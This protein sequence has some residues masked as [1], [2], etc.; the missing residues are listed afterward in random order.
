[1]KKKIPL[2]KISW[3]ND[4]ISLVR[5]TIARGMNWS[6]GPNVKRFENILARYVGTKY[7]I[8]F[9][10]GT[11]SLLAALYAHGIG[12]GDE[13]IVPS[14]S[15]ISVAMAP[16]F[17]NA[18]PVFVDIEDETLGIDP[19]RVEAKITNNTRAIIM[20][21]YGGCLSKIEEIK[22]IA[23]RHNLLLI[24]D[25]A[26]AFGLEIG[27]K[28]A[29]AFGDCGVFSFCQNKA[30]TTGD[31]GC[32]VTNS[33]DVLE[34]LSRINSYGQTN[35][36]CFYHDYVCLGLNLRMSDITAALGIAQMRKLKKNIRRRREVAKR[37]NEGLS[38]I[39][40][41]V[42]PDILSNKAA[43]ICLFYS[44]CVKA[45][46]RDR[47][48]THL[49]RNGITAKV[50]HY[51]AHLSTFFQQRSD[52]RDWDLPVT[53]RVWKEILSLP[54]YPDMGRNE[55]DYIVNCI[56]K[57]FTKTAKVHHENTLG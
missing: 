33:K 19:K 45:G 26:E 30:I 34:K 41:V 3:D 54:I 57:Y 25:A 11:S 43:S 31:G 38:R 28:K 6:A 47:L 49:H 52:H 12:S 5:D 22:R 15:F 37:L 17:V 23:E 44:I 42:L 2:F 10:S 46:A 8:V 55:I 32:V 53:E 50:Y 20:A 21:H 1:M 27:S 18:D 36:N 40:G 9:N 24:E 16:L 7:A 29:G 35:G 48:L 39:D 13:V 56:N 4:D 14:F 51:P